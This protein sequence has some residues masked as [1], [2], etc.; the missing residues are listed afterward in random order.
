M[1]QTTQSFNDI[2]REMW[3]QINSDDRQSVQPKNVTVVAPVLNEKT[4]IH[5]FLDSLLRQ[6]YPKNL[7]EVLFA[8][9][10]SWDGTTDIIR[11]RLEGQPLRYRILHNEGRTAP[12]AMNL[13]ISESSGEIIVRMDAHREYPSNYIT[14][15][16]Y[17][18]T[19]TDADNVGCPYILRGRGFV[20]ECIEK[21]LT[22]AF[23]VGGSDFKIGNDFY[24]DKVKTEYVDTVPLGTF[25]KE[26]ALLLGGFDEK[27]PR[28][29][30][31]DF[32]YR[33]RRTGGK[34][35]L[36]KGIHTVYY[37]R[38]SIPAMIR[39]G[40][41]NGESIGKVLFKAPAT[42]SIRHLIPFL[43]LL[44]I[45]IACI[46]AGTWTVFSAFLQA[47][48]LAYGLA[49]VVAAV[50]SRVNVWKT[51]FIVPIF[52]AL[53]FSYGIGTA[54]GLVKGFVRKIMDYDRY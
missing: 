28:A 21:A 44:S 19:T 13:G 6:D 45:I 7:T 42:V 54:V 31:N 20:G 38:S 9:G 16:V 52:P 11:E 50:S 14:N 32:N 30:D 39:M 10:G 41:G 33:L 4:Y 1:Y 51:L 25:M 23:G 34:I 3:K 43:F 5:E 27:Y 40:F 24:S 18:L 29:E 49:C 48:L 53:H 8:D 26:T 35:L 12:C 15:S 22:S 46:A 36:F 37:C 2:N 17:Y 47:E